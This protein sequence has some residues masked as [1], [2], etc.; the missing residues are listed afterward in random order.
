MRREG[1]A[2]G[3]R[4]RK[5]LLQFVPPRRQPGFVVQLRAQGE[6]RLTLNL[7]NAGPLFRDLPAERRPLG[8]QC[9]QALGRRWGG[10]R[11]L[12]QQGQG[13]QLVHVGRGIGG[14]DA[15]PERMLRFAEVRIHVGMQA[16]D[17]R[18]I[19]LFQ[20]AV[21]F[22]RE[23]V[24]EAVLRGLHPLRRLAHLLPAEEFQFQLAFD[25]AQIR[26]LAPVEAGLDQFD[27]PPQPGGGALRLEQSQ[28]PDTDGGLVE[29]EQVG[30][31]HAHELLGLGEQAGQLLAQQ[32]VFVR[33]AL[34]FGVE[35][36][37]GTHGW[38]EA[39]FLAA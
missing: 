35:V 17:E 25:R 10:A 13:T 33:Q 2:L 4:L 21:S 22:R 32:G 14:L 37:G 28:L 1:R 23:Q 34:G 27:F 5:L 11:P 36:G 19:E 20:L 38:L 8:A 26:R 18:V 3:L 6:G 39:G 9:L 12:R 15:T 16:L 24:L 7:F 29:G 30:L 31:H